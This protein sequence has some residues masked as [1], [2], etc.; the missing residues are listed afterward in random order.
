MKYFAS[1]KS[2]LWRVKHIYTIIIVVGDIAV[3]ST[4][5]KSRLTYNHAQNTALVEHVQKIIFSWLYHTQD[6][7]FWEH[8]CRIQNRQS[9]Y[10]GG[11]KGIKNSVKNIQKMF[12]FV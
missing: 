4:V 3:K 1:R 5:S 2:S 7:N 11:E 12:A 6:E 9:V 8:Q 10:K